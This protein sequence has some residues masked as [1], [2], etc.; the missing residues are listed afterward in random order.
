M[1]KNPIVISTEPEQQG[2]YP[3]AIKVEPS[4]PFL[5]ELAKLFRAHQQTGNALEIC[6]LGLTYFPENLEIRL[7]LALA[8]LDSKQDLDAFSELEA[9]SKNLSL[10][11]PYLEEIGKL[12]KIT[13]K[14][15]LS[16]W[17]FLMAET[18]LRFPTDTEPQEEYQV[19]SK[20]IPTLTEWVNQL[21]R[22]RG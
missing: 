17:A 1:K 15:S 2:D 20:V 19:E 3:L 22:E 8:H 21:K 10:L 13:G 16:E 12:A 11:A 9:V 7:L 18:L 4:V 5:A 6:R 14:E